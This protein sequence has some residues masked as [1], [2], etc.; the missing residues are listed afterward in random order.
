MRKRKT[1]D[2]ESSEMEVLDEEKADINDDD[3]DDNEG[4]DNMS[5]D[6]ED[7]DEEFQ[8]VRKTSGPAMVDN[9]FLDSFYS[10]SSEDAKE[11]SRAAQTMLHHCMLSSAANSKDAAYAFRRLL[12]GICSG[13]AAARQ[14]N[15]SALASFL[16][17]AFHLEKMEDIREEQ[18][19][20]A[21]TESLSL[22]AYVR[23]RLMVA[24]DPNQT[25][26]K[27]KGSEERD[28]QFGR[29]FG[30][31]AVVR[32]NIL[33]SHSQENVEDAKDIAT[34]LTTDLVELFWLK[35]WMREPAAHGITTLLRPFC[36]ATSKKSVAKH[37]VEKV[38]IPKVLLMSSIGDEGEKDHA[39]LVGSF[40]A[41]Q[42]GIALFVQSQSVFDSR[43][44][45]FP[46]NHGIMSKE[47]V[48]VCAQAL[49]ETSVVVQPRMHFVW[50]SLWNYLTHPMEKSGKRNVKEPEKRVLRES[51]PGGNENTREVLD[52]IV[53]QVLMQKLL[54]IDP[55]KS[56]PSGKATHER[57]AL[58]LCIVKILAGVPYVSSVSGASRIV[59]E[60]EV[61]GHTVFSPEMVRSLF[62]DIICAGSEKKKTSHL[63][64]PLALEVLKEVSEGIVLD[65]SDSSEARRLAVAKAL[66]GCEIRFDARTKTSTVSDLLGLMRP[67]PEGKMASSFSF[68]NGYLE[69]LLESLLGQCSDIK[70]DDNS[71]QANGY[72]ELIYSFAKHILRVQTEKSEHQIE[73]GQFK[74]SVVDKILRFFLAA[75]FFNCE[76]IN[77]PETNTPKKK[78]GKKAKKG[79]ENP[80]LVI[81]QKLQHTQAKGAGIVHA[82]R[83]VISARFF[84]LL[85]D[86]SGYATHATME[87]SE[88]KLEK[89]STTLGVLVD[90]C[91]SWKSL[92]ALG[93]KR[94]TSQTEAGDSNDDE[95]VDPEK[96]VNEMQKMVKAST[97][98]ASKDPED[99]S[100]ASK[101]RCCT[102]MAV[103]GFSLYLHRL[104]C[105]EGDEDSDDP[106]ADDENDE[107]EIC[108]ALEGLKNVADD[109]MEEPEEES[110]PLLG[111]AELCANVLSSPLGSGNMGRA[112]SPKLIREAVKFA[113][114][115]GLRL[116]SI[117][118]SEDRTLLDASVI[119]ILLEAVG[120]SD[121]KEGNM[122]EDASDN[123]DDDDDANEEASS[124]DESMDENVF[125]KATKVVE[126]PEDMQIEGEDP[127]DGDSDDSDLELDPAKLQSML[128]ED[129]DADIDEEVLEH[130]EGADAALAKLIKLKQEARKAG[131]QAKE[132]IEI[133]H[134]LR[135]TFL[136]E[137][138]FGRPDA[139]NRLFRTE[140][141]LAI[142]LPML[143][144]RQTL[145]RSLK[146]SIESSSK[147]G[148]GEKQ[149][150][151]DRLTNLLTQKICKM[152]VA[153]LPLAKPLPTQSAAGYASKMLGEARRSDSKEQSSCC[154][155]C[156]VFLFRST[157]DAANGS[158]L[159][160][161]CEEAVTEWSTKRTTKLEANLFDE[162][163]VHLPE[164]SQTFLARPLSKA[165]QS[166]RSPFLKAESF[167]LV[168]LLFSTNPGTQD[169]K[170]G[171]TAEQSLVAA[172]EDFL[173]AV[174]AALQ[175]EEMRKAKR[176]RVILKALEKFVAGLTPPAT[177]E[178]YTHLDTIK[179]LLGKLGEGESQGVSA[180]CTK[181]VSEMDA[182]TVELKTKT[183][184]LKGSDGAAEKQEPA[185]QSKA[186]EE[187][188]VSN[189]KKKKKKKKKR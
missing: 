133:G 79:P 19:T 87:D 90:V 61:L 153:S 76:D 125:S 112:A 138:L 109:F 74:K 59:L 110:N 144:H 18:E 6:D 63:L 72:V 165:A 62:L 136:L 15:A 25:T 159:V 180:M 173:T 17:L 154:N 186:G 174:E 34:A 96:V 163:I 24:T 4:E 70:G 48:E 54:R 105:G 184:E 113:W 2:D 169:S 98:A 172:R 46:L 127:Q 26:G 85:A 91:E 40:C 157:S 147:S 44:M 75:A 164:I 121:Q 189:S 78:K 140:T 124:D 97:E 151:L 65:T 152:K 170:S 119:E 68:W 114:L 11:R 28:Y 31:L 171:Q 32:S 111:L 83:A 161:I 120:L 89:D 42:L 33:I 57:R 176:V 122:E 77:E 155:S 188:D 58:A 104:S 178:I 45:P 102:G 14:G 141:L 123:D 142:S 134:Q 117:T 84:S 16:K 81:A 181:L 166:A 118:A 35:K 41:E 51:C 71:A 21:D 60:G 94:Y 10:L 82:V 128:E 137:L 20:G 131:K 103:L 179:G 160:T 139:W 148:M 39:T 66:L 116:A 168:T 158:V 30:I 37:L 156:L 27:K 80:L 5:G 8:G 64:K 182:K 100:A 67:I 36:E 177:K 107:E 187:W 38:V 162:M 12:N 69:Y 55:E 106:D 86:Y 101:K 126:D 99:V 56:S 175:D 185:S 7:E 3:D 50:D 49:G 1:S 43:A 129:S 73:L 52:L 93:A 47:T 95:S 53:Q 167:R 135:S 143:K 22:L 88:N 130:H 115:G 108:N 145:E 23:H 9:P 150:L 92:E 29:L 132:K 183:V 149:A 13:R 146:K